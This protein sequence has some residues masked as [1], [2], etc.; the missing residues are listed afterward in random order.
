MKDALS[1][2]EEIVAQG[3]KLGADEV[4]AKTTFG[5]YRQARFSNNQVDI[6][7][8]WNDYVTDVVFAWK[9]RIVATQ[10][11]NFQDVD[12]GLRNLL[13]LAKVSKEN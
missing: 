12:V 8:A 4:I 6:T 3:K 5:K 1:Q 11:H 2:T 9:K 13:K 10:V 7:V